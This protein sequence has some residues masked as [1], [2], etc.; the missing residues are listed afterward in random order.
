MKISFVKRP[1]AKPVR[2]LRLISL[3]F[4]GCVTATG[5]SINGYGLVAT[6]IESADGAVLYTHH[7]PGIQVRIEPGDVGVSL[8]FT[9]RLCIGML[10]SESAASGWYFGFSPPPPL[11]CYARELSTWG[12]ELRL[13]QPDF[14]VGVGVRQTVILGQVKQEQLVNYLLTYDSSDT[15][16]TRLEEFK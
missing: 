2:V 6:K 5:C 14:S 10:G 12:G 4:F 1:T 15:Q 9:R 16:A 7:A 11:E 3:G 13:S 8:G